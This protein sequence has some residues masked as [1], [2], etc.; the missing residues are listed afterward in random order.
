MDC[1]LNDKSKTGNEISMKQNTDV[2]NLH[3]KLGRV[4]AQYRSS[5]EESPEHHQTIT[6]YYA[7]FHELVKRCGTIVALDPDA[8]LPDHLMPK[9]YVAFWLK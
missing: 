3:I 4:A 1:Y 5:L 2:D 7:V 8:E 6:E 9:E